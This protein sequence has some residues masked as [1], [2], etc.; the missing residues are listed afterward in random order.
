[1][2]RIEKKQIPNY[3]SSK[4]DDQILQNY[5]SAGLENC[6]PLVPI[7]YVYVNS[8]H[9]NTISKKRITYIIQTFNLACL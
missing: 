3:D 6:F 8:S 7:G 5:P 1:M 9:R 4:A 2:A